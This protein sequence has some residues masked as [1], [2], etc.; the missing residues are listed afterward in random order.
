MPY[1]ITYYSE[2]VQHDVLTLPP[3]IL[4]SYLR[5]ADM[6]EVFGPSLRMPHSR[7]M[8]N[9][10]FELR[11]KGR[12]GIGRVFYCFQVGEQIMVL[13]SFVKKTQETPNREL[14]IALTRMQEVKNAHSR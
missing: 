4:A 14:N 3:S 12:E 6:L 13:H 11:P 7:A 10:L 8:G 2:S 1:T 5:L 9:G